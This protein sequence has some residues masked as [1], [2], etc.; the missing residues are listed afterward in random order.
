MAMGMETSYPDFYRYLKSVTNKSALLNQL[1][2][3]LDENKEL[4]SDMEEGLGN[5]TQNVKDPED[6]IKLYKELNGHL[7][8]YLEKQEHNFSL[9]EGDTMKLISDFSNPF[10]H[11]PKTDKKTV[12]AFVSGLDKG[13]ESVCFIMSF[14]YTNTIEKILGTSSDRSLGKGARL[15]KIIHVHGRLAELD[16]II[17]GVDTDEQIANEEFRT[18]VNVR[19]YM[20]KSQSNFAM[21]ETREEECEELIKTANVIIIYGASLG[22]TDEK[23]WKLIKDQMGGRENI[24]VI[25]YVYD[26]NFPTEHIQELGRYERENRPKFLGRLGI[27]NENYEANL[28]NR[29]FLMINRPLFRVKLTNKPTIIEI[30]SDH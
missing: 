11:L 19:D 14:N 1:I 15:E 3:E 4:W 12:D 13:N 17:I 20:V 22:R 8:N 27:S 7:K 6:F 21:K 30:R 29:F 26:K 10:G 23:W 9:S 25:L 2:K 5:F 24:I 18:N 28:K 16:S